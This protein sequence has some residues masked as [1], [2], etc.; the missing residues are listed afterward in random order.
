MEEKNNDERPT[1]FEDTLDVTESKH[2][3]E[4]RMQMQLFASATSDRSTNTIHIYDIAPKFSYN[5]SPSNVSETAFRN[6]SMRVAGDE[7]PVEI[8]AARIKRNNG[9][10]VLIWPGEREECIEDSLRKLATSGQGILVNGE[11]GVRFTLY[12]LRTELKNHKH[13]YSYD[14]LREGLY[15]LRRAGLRITNPLTGESWEEG[16]L[17]RLVEGGQRGVKDGPSYEPWYASFHKLVTKSITDLTY[18]QMNYPRLMS[19]PGQLAKYIYKR[20]VAVYTFADL[21][22]PYQPSL[23]QILEESGRGVSPDMKINIKAMNRALSQLKA[24]GATAHSEELKRVKQGRKVLNI[25][26]NIFPTQQFVSEIIEANKQQKKHRA[27]A[28][29]TMIQQIKSTIS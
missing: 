27:N 12:Q 21:D 7:Y 11:A 20:M 5:E 3:I 29:K 15:V 1:S 8:Q 14:Q 6:R 2:D 18:R 13:T 28:K 17:S 23:I 22:K 26:Y 16:F 4:N 10:E 9:E 25:R 19:I 24:Q